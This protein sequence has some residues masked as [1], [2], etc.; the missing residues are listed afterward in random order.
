M[1]EMEPKSHSEPVAVAGP[2]LTAASPPKGSLI[3]QTHVLFMQVSFLY[4]NANR[5]RILRII[6][7]GVKVSPS[8]SEVFEACDYSVLANCTRSSPGLVRKAVPCFW[9]GRYSLVDINN[10]VVQ[11]ARKAYLQAAQI[12]KADGSESPL[13]LL[14]MYTLGVLK[15]PVFNMHNMVS[16]LC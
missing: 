10:S 16:R 3:N 1:V 9:D 2:Q 14:P 5:E 7:H 6:N 15:H 13:A 4:T 8:V 12:A 11:A